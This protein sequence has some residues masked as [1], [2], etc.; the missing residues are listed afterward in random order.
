MLE[1]RFPDIGEGI[2]EGV[3]LKWFVEAGAEVKEG[4]SLFLVE[5]DKVNAEIPSPASGKVLSTIGAVG[6]TINV[7]DVVVRIDD[8]SSQEDRAPVSTP[9][10]TEAVEEENAGVVGALE[11]SSHV[12]ETSREG[13]P[14]R[15]ATGGRKVLATPVARHLAKELGVDINQVIGTGPAGRVMKDDIRKDAKQAQQGEQLAIAPNGVRHAAEER[16][17]LTQLGKTVAKTM[18]L[19]KQEI[20]H[21]AVMDEFDVTELVRFRQEAKVLADKEG[22]KLT[23]MAFIVKAVALTLQEFPLFNASFAADT[24][25]IVLQKHYNIGIAVD[26]ADGLLVPVI[27][28]ANRLG[29]LSLADQ[30]RALAEK[31]RERTLTLDEIQGG[32]FTLTN[33]GAVGALSGLPVIKYPEAGILGIGTITKKPVVDRDDAIVIRHILPVTLAFDHRFIDGGNAGRFM[34]RLRSYLEQPVLLLLS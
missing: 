27:K 24:Q 17:P 13:S 11:T 22:S 26:T 29:V 31:A 34:Q 4:D 30:V 10:K 2:A 18:A 5:T 1:F 3:I 7:G 32:T 6:D 23:Y 33:Y 15:A 20:P 16:V 14:K 12:L 19:S 9:T 21:A 25:E 28:H 8:G